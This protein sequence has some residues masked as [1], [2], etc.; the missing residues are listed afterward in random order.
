[1][2]SGST[3]TIAGVSADIGG[4]AQSQFNANHVISQVEQDQYAITTSSNA[5]STTNGGGTA[6]TATENKH[7]DILYP[8]CLL[9]TSPSPR[10]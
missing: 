3:V 4:I 5:T 10:D 9:Y 1:M 7:I 2:P 6:I 8:T